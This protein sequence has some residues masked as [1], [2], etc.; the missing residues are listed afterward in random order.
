M[1]SERQH[2]T[3]RA[4]VSIFAG[5]VMAGASVSAWADTQPAPRI[6][7]AFTFTKVVDT[8]TKVPGGA[9]A[10]FD[11]N[12]TDA[13]AVSGGNVVFDTGDSVIWTAT[14]SGGN[15]KKVLTPDTF[16]PFGHGAKFTQFYG[17]FVS[18]AGNTVVVDAEL[19][20]GCT[21]G[22]GI[23]TRPV[24]GG[25]ITRLADMS[26]F[27]P[28]STTQKYGFFPVDW[29]A[30]G[31]N[32]VFQNTYQV[33]S[34]P[35]AGGKVTAVAGPQDAGFSPPVPYCCGFEHPTLSD[36]TTEVLLFGGVDFG[37]AQIQT[38]KRTGVPY[39]FRVIADLSTHPPHTPLAY[40]FYGH[41]FGAPVIDQTVDHRYYV[42][43]GLS[44][45]PS[46]PGDINGI[47]SRGSSG[48]Q[49]L[50]DTNTPV[51]GGTGK[52]ARDDCCGLDGFEEIG[53][54]NGVVVFRG[55]DGAG[56]MGLYAVSAGGGPITKIIAQGDLLNGFTNPVAQI[57]M[58]RDG[59]DGTTL[60]FMVIFGSAREIGIYTTRVVL[61]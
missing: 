54:G 57:W 52:F 26:E 48:F 42:F 41:K 38:V 8:H 58:R 20:G 13:P 2:K 16:I 34:V 61:P 31:S 25:P 10:Y 4:A 33:F 5:I 9:G 46:L 36:S 37:N 24:S 15:L 50:V 30:N 39:S 35:L 43:R 56:L 18:I 40:R 27:I 14:T 45:D 17:E 28:G 32:L 19:C 22:V 60:G 49:R 1:R 59:F 23:Y 29:H 11:F 53:A 44:H 3:P 7:A 12:V 55:V 51:P 21:T 47:Y 6:A